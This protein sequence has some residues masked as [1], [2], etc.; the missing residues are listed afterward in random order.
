[1]GLEIMCNGASYFKLLQLCASDPYDRP[2]E[3]VI[4]VPSVSAGLGKQKVNSHD[5][6]Y[7]SLFLAS[8]M[9]NATA[10]F[11]FFLI[12]SLF[13]RESIPVCFSDGAFQQ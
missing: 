13:Q 1:M 8:I 3:D 9:S 12:D 10:T 4:C 7:N 2:K 6:V 5:P 11:L